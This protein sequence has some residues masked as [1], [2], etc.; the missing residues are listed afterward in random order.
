M[1]EEARA[2]EP[3]PTTITMIGIVR[4]DADALEYLVLGD[5]T[6]LSTPGTSSMW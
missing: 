2:G 4:I 5:T 6:I 1:P 3:E